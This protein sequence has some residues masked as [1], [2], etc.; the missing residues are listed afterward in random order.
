MKMPAKSFN[1]P[2]RAAATLC[3]GLT[4]LVAWGSSAGVANAAG[5]RRVLAAAGCPNPLLIQTSWFPEITKLGTY[6]IVGPHGKVDTTH[7]IYYGTVGGVTVQIASGGPY[8]GTENDVSEL[9]LNPSV[10]MSDVTT[11]TQIV[12]YAQHPTLAV[13]APLQGTPLGMIWDPGV[14]HFTSIKTIGQ[15]GVT[16]LKAGETASADLLTVEGIVKATQWTFSYDGSPGKFVAS[17]GKDVISDFIDEAPYSYDHFPQWAGKPKLAYLPLSQYVDTYGTALV[18]KPSTARKYSKCLHALIPMFQKAVVKLLKNPRPMSNALISE[19]KLL[20]SLSPIT[21][22]LNNFT[23]KVLAQTNMLANGP[24]G[25]YGSFTANRVK[26]MI[27]KLGPVATFE[28]LKL[29]PGLRAGQLVTNK[30]LDK[31]IH[32]AK[33][34][35]LP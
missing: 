6:A 7:G 32:L 1:R 10:F 2:L 23:L 35:N 29:Q 17:G 18:V 20:N 19:A 31:S 16:I 26:G 24:N 12:D 4:A 25:V 28:H 21:T 33:H 14:H 15:S 30:F 34:L 11:T 5:S 8:Q 9:Y 22:G 13:M 3:V 27:A